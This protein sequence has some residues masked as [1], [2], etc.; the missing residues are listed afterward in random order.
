[1]HM[2]QMQNNT[3]K[4][5]A[6]WAF[7]FL[8]ILWIFSNSLMNGNISS[9]TSGSI[10]RQILAFLAFFGIN[11]GYDVFHHFIRKLAHFLEYTLLGFL[12]SFSIFRRSLFSSEKLT[13]LTICILTPILDETLQLFVPGRCGSLTDSLLDMSGC[14]FGTLFLLMLRKLHFHFTQKKKGDN[15]PD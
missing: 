4:E 3:L 15:L 1:M 14:I 12:T 5:K 9:S 7:I 13:W 8:Y 2:K 10:T 6:H 11:P